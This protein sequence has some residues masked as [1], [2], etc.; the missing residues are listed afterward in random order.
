MK[1]SIFIFFTMIFLSLMSCDKNRSPDLF[2]YDETGCSDA[3]WNDSQ[4]YDTLTPDIYR[5]IVASYLD[6]KNIELIS[7]GINYDSA[8]AE[9]CRACFC[10][11][12]NV[13]QVEVEA[14]RKQKMRSIGFYP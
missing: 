1:N 5:E 10:R 9:A 6:D 11:T 3:W 4:S 14:G 13:L 12:G 2:Y 8:K 7:F